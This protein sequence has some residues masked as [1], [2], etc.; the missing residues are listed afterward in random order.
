MSNKNNIDTKSPDAFQVG[1]Y[2]FFDWA[3]KNKKLLMGL[4]LPVVLVFAGLWGW[5]QISATKAESRRYELAKIDDLFAK[6]EESISKDREEIQKKLAEFNDDKKNATK[7][8][9]KIEKL[10]KDLESLQADHSESLKKYLDFLNQN[11]N[12]AEGMR[13]GLV[14]ANIELQNKKFDNAK[15]ILEKVLSNVPSGAFYN[16]QVRLLYAGVLEEVGEKEKALAEVDKVLLNVMDSI[17]PK[18][19]FTKGRILTELDRKEEAQAVFS[20][21]TLKY[22]NSQE[23]RKVAA[24][25]LI[26][27]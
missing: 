3:L 10:E 24:I 11:L 25:K 16:V 20:E 23:A 13:A 17:K 6:E 18:V 26:Q 21:L 5:S 22:A 27:K 1:M 2:K 8:K 14:A 15:A 4:T 19:L 12:S 7:N 9:A